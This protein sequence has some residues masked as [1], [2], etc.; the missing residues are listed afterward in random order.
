MLSPQVLVTFFSHVSIPDVKKDAMTM[1]I[2][3]DISSA[4]EENYAEDDYET[5]LDDDIS[6]PS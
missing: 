5:S 3:E 2:S 1:G 4:E 6:T